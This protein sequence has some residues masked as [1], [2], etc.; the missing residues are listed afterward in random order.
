MRTSDEMFPIVEDWLQSGLT[1]KAYSQ[2]HDLPLHILPYWASRYRKAHHAP[3]D[4]SAQSSSGHFIPVSTG[5]TINGGMEIALPTGVVISFA[6][7]VP[8]SYLQQVLKAC[9]A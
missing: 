1:Q 6:D 2:G 9:S 4:Q 3:I 5:N 8:A 7:L